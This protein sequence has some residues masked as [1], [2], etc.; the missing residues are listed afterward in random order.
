[1]AS[2]NDQKENALVSNT[3]AAI[4]AT[5]AIEI[6]IAQR[7]GF[8]G[9]AIT[10]SRIRNYLDAAHSVSDLKATLDGIPIYG[11]GTILD[12]ERHG[13]DTQSPMSSARAI[14]GFAH[15]VGAKG[16]QLVTGPIDYREVMR[17]R[18][19]CRRVANVR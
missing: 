16:V 11:V 12:I 4:H 13:N 15:R 5:L 6:D 17:F 19:V 8:D 1:M 14:L 7:I 9:L 18:E 10:G 3:I 2:K